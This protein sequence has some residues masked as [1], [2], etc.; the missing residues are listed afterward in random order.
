MIHGANY[1]PQDFERLTTQAHPLFRDESAAAY[2]VGDR[3]TVVVETSVRGDRDGATEAAAEAVRAITEELPVS[4]DVVVVPRGQIPR[5][6]S[7]KP[8]RHECGPRHANGELTVLARW[9]R[10]PGSLS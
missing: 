10:D 9:P 2:A 6:T 5:T 8:R 7:G 4:T 3:V 1:Y